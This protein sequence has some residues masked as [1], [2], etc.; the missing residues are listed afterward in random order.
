MLQQTQVDRV[1]PVWQ[2]WMDRWPTPQSLATAAL[3]DVLRAWGRLGYPRR[4]RWLWQAAQQITTR[5]DGDVPGDETLLR[6]LPG[7]GT[8]TAA[9]V[10]AFAFDQSTVVLDTNV[11]RVLSR[12]VLGEANSPAHIT[13]AERAL[14]ESLL[15]EHDAALWSVAVMEL[16]ALVCRASNPKCTECPIADDCAWRA[17]GYPEGAHPRRAA[18]PFAGSDRQARGVIL[19]VLRESHSAVPVDAFPI[20]D[21]QQHARALQTLVD[22]GLVDHV[23]GKY[24]LPD[25]S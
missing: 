3:D 19:A 7:I 5:Y 25:G 15:P 22:D 8:Y 10:C 2:A 24:A 23:D 12:A 20:T 9:A 4:A 11:R 16:G 18:R 1:L 14:A 6:D 17:A 13:T 21:P